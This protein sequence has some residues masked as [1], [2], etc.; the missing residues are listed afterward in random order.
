MPGGTI[1][2]LSSRSIRSKAIPKV[3]TKSLDMYSVTGDLGAPDINM[4]GREITGNKHPLP[5]DN[6]LARIDPGGRLVV[7]YNMDFMKA[8]TQGLFDTPDT[9]SNIYGVPS[10]MNDFAIVLLSG[11]STKGGGKENSLLINNKENTRK[12]YE[13]DAMG[14]ESRKVTVSK[15][16]SW[17]QDSGNKAKRPYSY[18]DFIYLKYF[19]KIPL[20]HQITLRRFPFPVN[21]GLHF[22]QEDTDTDIKPPMAQA[23]T[24]MGEETG[25]SMSSFFEMD[26]GLN[27]E[28]FQA[29][30]WDQNETMPG[31]DA[32]PGMLGTVA[33]YASV[34][35][36][37]SNAGTVRNQ[38]RQLPDPYENGPYAN[39]I[40]G[41]VNRI[42][43]TKRRAAGLRF[44]Q[45]ITLNFHY[46]AREIGGIN[47]KA[48]MLDIIANLL[49]LT[50]ATAPFWGGAN[51]F[52][53]GGPA[54]PFDGMKEWYAG[55]GGGFFEKL[56]NSF[57]EGVSN[58]SEFFGKL[59][60][61]PIGALKDAIENGVGSI[62]NHLMA[63][64]T[65]GNMPSY[66]GLRSILTGEPVGEWHVTVGNPLNPIMEIGNL[67]CSGISF[68]VGNTLG[69]DD[70]PEELNATI[71]L[72]HGMPRD[73]DAIS[74]MFNRGKGRIYSLPDDFT[75]ASSNNETKIDKFTGE[76]NPYLNRLQGGVEDAKEHPGFGGDTT[77]NVAEVD[78]AKDG[79]TSLVK[80]IRDAGSNIYIKTGRMAFGWSNKDDKKTTKA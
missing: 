76:N 34:G 62:A 33:K 42:D 77:K 79:A 24:Y 9:E 2:K 12:W 41:P 70:F 64:K 78:K 1:T 25:N 13:E 14:Y 50:Y 38:D 21:D 40:M 27:W 68:S 60:D 57:G 5:V 10:V 58:L 28:D 69:P 80:T 6:R 75:D 73:S 65:A 36:G 56:T 71:T 48:A 39:R 45:T 67:V 31:S 66:L 46:V 54:Y 8:S 44:D 35:S 72:E 18:A 4:E 3:S 51:R 16:I 55:E 37:Q 11:A 59:I 61:D 30:V 49:A 7:P 43:T 52:T 22:P 17:S 15:L 26:F 47:P 23:I 32:L 74:N 29:E 19:T 20:N 53:V 63:R